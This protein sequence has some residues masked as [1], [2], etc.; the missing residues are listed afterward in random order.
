[1]Y[2]EVTA[3][4]IAS[5]YGPSSKIT[6][7]LWNLTQHDLPWFIRTLF[8]FPCFAFADLAL[9]LLQLSFWNAKFISKQNVCYCYISNNKPPSFNPTKKKTHLHFDTILQKQK[10]PTMSSSC[11]SART[12]SGFWRRLKEPRILVSTW[13]SDSPTVIT[14]PKSWF[15]STDSKMIC[16]MIFKGIVFI[17]YTY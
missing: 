9:C 2:P 8:L 6:L 3:F 1:M 12:S 13:R 5:K 17:H 7:H 16:T 14:R 10:N 4:H 15:T 11:H